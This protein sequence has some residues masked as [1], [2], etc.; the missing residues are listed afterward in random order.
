ME[1]K[2]EEDSVIKANLTFCI[3]YILFALLKIY[4][5][6]ISEFLICKII[7]K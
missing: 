4:H 5:K 7:S 3:Y 1:L 6:D 2:T